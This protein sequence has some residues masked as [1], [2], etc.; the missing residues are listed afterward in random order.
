MGPTRSTGWLLFRV[1]NFP[2]LN[3]VYVISANFQFII[4]IFIVL[5]VEIIVKFFIMSALIPAFLIIFLVLHYLLLIPLQQLLLPF[6]LFESLPIPLHPLLISHITELVDSQLIWRMLVRLDNS[7][8]LFEYL[9][10][11][12]QVILWRVLLLVLSDE[13][14]ECMLNF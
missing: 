6:V 10:L 8:I 2:F 1:A 14:Y 5:V 11:S 12:Q 13:R 3:P 7:E 9:K 4:N